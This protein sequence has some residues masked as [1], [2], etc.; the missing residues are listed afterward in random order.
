MRCLTSWYLDLNLHAVSYLEIIS[1]G[2]V[3]DDLDMCRG[4]Y[5]GHGSHAGDG[6]GIK[7]NMV[8]R[9]GHETCDSNLLGEFEC[10]RLTLSQIKTLKAN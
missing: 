8:H 5:R 7:C 10:K 1:G 3:V 4:W 2:D 6:E 9:L